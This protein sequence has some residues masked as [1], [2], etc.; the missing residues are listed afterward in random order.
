MLGLSNPL[1]ASFSQAHSRQSTGKEK[2]KALYEISSLNFLFFFCHPVGIFLCITKVYK[3]LK[4][5]LSE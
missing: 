1:F 5:I 3:V 4:K 2:I